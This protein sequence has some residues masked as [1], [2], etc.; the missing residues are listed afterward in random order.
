MQK[1]YDP[2]N[3]EKVKYI[4]D[5]CSHFLNIHKFEMEI[6]FRETLLSTLNPV[7]NEELHVE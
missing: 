2:T 4:D 7:A 3:I 1:S 6:G 5:A